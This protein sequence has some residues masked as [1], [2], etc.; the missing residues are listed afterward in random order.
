M[1]EE[2]SLK[3]LKWNF[4]T[5]WDEYVE[6]LKTQMAT[7]L[8]KWLLDELF[9]YDFQHQVKAV[10]AMIEHMEAE[11]EAVVGCLDLILK[12]FTL[13]FF[14]TS[15]SILMKAMEFLKLLFTMLSRENYHLSEYEASS[16]IPYLIQ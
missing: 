9:H 13:R 7:C 10:N 11:A 6:Q 2:K 16:V 15:T 14:D 12:W 4:I 8:A 1:K 5:S 3:I